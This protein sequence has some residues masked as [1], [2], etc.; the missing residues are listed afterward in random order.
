MKQTT[1]QFNFDETKLEAISI[2]L[3]TKE[4]TL[5]K[6]LEDFMESLY[7]KTVPTAVREFIEK[8]AGQVEKESQRPGKRSTT[9]SSRNT[10]DEEMIDRVSPTEN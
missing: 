5:N 9:R 1:I 3:K 8:K 2:Y 7:K 4:G 10:A 6:E